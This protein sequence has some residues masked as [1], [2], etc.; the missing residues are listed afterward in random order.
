MMYGFAKL[1]AGGEIEVM[2]ND[3]DLG[4]TDYKSGLPWG[5]GQ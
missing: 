4:D 1:G 2:E 3:L 5:E